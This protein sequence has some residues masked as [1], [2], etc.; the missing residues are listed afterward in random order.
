MKVAEVGERLLDKII[1]RQNN[2]DFDKNLLRE[3]G[4]KND[5]ELCGVLRRFENPKKKLR[6]DVLWCEA[7]G[8]LENL[9]LGTVYLISG[10]GFSY[11]YYL[12]AKDMP[13]WGVSIFY[14]LFFTAVAMLC[15][16]YGAKSFVNAWSDYRGLVRFLRNI[17]S[18]SAGEHR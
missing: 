10:I 9:A 6:R 13:I 17:R 11:L 16:G 14:L 1:E 5:P 15:G 2:G 8:L 7:I 4:I 18:K 12:I 3:L